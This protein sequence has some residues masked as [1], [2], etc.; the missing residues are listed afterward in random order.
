[1]KNVE[2]RAVGVNVIK[3]VTPA[4]Q[5]VKFVRDEL[6]ELM[7]KES[8]PLMQ[9]RSGPTVVLMVGLQGVGKTTACGKLALFLKNQGKNVNLVATDVYRPAAIE[10]LK[11]L[12][13]QV[14]CNVFDLGT[15][16]KPAEIARRGI[17]EASK[18]KADYVIVDTSGRLQIDAAMMGE[19]KDVMRAC[20]PD[21]VLLVV[22]AMT[23]Q[24][25]ANLVK[26]FNDSIG[27]TGAVLSKMDG[28]TRG[29][30]A[31][32]IREISGRPVKFTGV[33]EK[34]SA[35]EPF[36]PDRMVN[37][38]LGMG[39]VLSLVEKAQSAIDEDE[40]EKM[41]KK[42]ED[43]SFDYNDFL[44]Q[45][46]MIANM[47]SMSSMIKM[48]PGMGKISNQQLSDAER[49]NNQY[50]AMIFSMTKEER[51]DPDL[52]ARSLSRRSRIAKG[53]GHTEER[54]SK[55]VAQFSAMRKQMQ[56]MMELTKLGQGVGMGDEVCRCRFLSF[57]TRMYSRKLQAKAFAFWRSCNWRRFICGELFFN[58]FIPPKVT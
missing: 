10:Q 2:E 24:E 47:G 6:L 53:S 57:C 13:S 16:Y 33:G 19:L 25:A 50:K 55:L 27:I 11:T 7:G 15:T 36:Y 29:G 5:L 39:D 32:T 54:V 38:I 31:L 20:K 22:D 30:A 9:A 49:S 14:G 46:E 45:T 1:V 17:K 56:N 3:G 18:E 52:L 34:M 43:A 42:I 8:A 21:E 4:Q 37:R 23:G 51:K 58:Q 28:D 41:M 26:T 12:G 40:A 44:K 48:M 35:L